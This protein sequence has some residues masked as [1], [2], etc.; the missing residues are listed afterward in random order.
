MNWFGKALVIGMIAIA[1]IPSDARANEPPVD[2]RANGLRAVRAWPIDTGIVRVDR[3]PDKSPMR[4]VYLD[5]FEVPDEG[6]LQALEMGVARAP[7]GASTEIF[8]RLKYLARKDG[9]SLAIQR[10][11]MQFYATGPTENWTVAEMD[12]NGWVRASQRAELVTRG[13]RIE[14]YTAVEKGGGNL[15]FTLPN[16]E[17]KLVEPGGSPSP[18]LLRMFTDCFCKVMTEL[19]AEIWHGYVCR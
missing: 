9:Q 19:P 6:G 3:A 8:F 17:P 4:C 2:P 5:R 12:R 10:P 11:T 7:N 1:A 16:G 15:V 14:F 13:E 18:K